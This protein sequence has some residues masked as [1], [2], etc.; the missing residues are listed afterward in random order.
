M[1]KIY[2]GLLGFGNVGLGVM[3][4]LRARKSLLRKKL[5]CDLVLKKVCDKDSAARRKLRLP[6]DMFTSDASQVLNDPGIDIVIELIGGIHPAKEF[7]IQCLNNKFR[8]SMK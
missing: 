4:I 7:I 1:K 5:G 8:L 2:L 6:R 3:K